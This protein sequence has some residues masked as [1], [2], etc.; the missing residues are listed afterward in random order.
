MDIYSWW[1]VF[2]LMRLALPWAMPSLHAPVWHRGRS[3]WSVPGE[4]WEMTV[5]YEEPT[6][7]LQCRLKMTNSGCD[8]SSS[9]RS[10]KLIR[11]SVSWECKSIPGENWEMTT[12]C[13]RMQISVSIFVNDFPI[14]DNSQLSAPTIYWFKTRC[15]FKGDGTLIQKS[16]AIFANWCDRVSLLCKE[17]KE[18]HT[19]QNMLRIQNY[20]W[21]SNLDFSRLR[22]DF[23]WKLRP[24]SMH[25]VENR[26]LDRNF[27][28]EREGGAI[29][30]EV[31]LTIPKERENGDCLPVPI[32]Y[33]MPTAAPVG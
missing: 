24:E 33:K 14:I 1:D 4:N 16:V 28:G 6:I 5:S 10:K 9:R 21:S 15:C 32:E 11:S 20:K 17:A 29:H 7:E 2:S 13:N 8:R 18:G 26:N 3:L 19:V 22:T 30:L 23:C 27:G 25:A 12:S 31:Q